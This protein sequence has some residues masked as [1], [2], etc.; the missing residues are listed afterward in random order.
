[1]QE[2]P[3]GEQGDGEGELE[4]S[5]CTAACIHLLWLSAEIFC[6]G[7][8]AILHYLVLRKSNNCISICKITTC[9][10]LTGYKD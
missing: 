7:F 8:L 6:P 9:Q 3:F 1:M 5:S 4:L 2:K 10:Y